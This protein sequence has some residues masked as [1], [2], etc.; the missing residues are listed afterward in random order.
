MS[1]NDPLAP[2]APPQWT[3]SGQPSN[4]FNAPLPRDETALNRFLGGSPGGVFLR[5]VFVSLI[6]GAFLMW[7]DIRPIDIFRGIK[8]LIDRIWGLGFDAIREIGNYILAGAAI[9]IPVWLVLRLMNMRN[10]R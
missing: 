4:P 1:E 6:V 10:G 5:L 8:D 2:K 7:L 9:V 3:A